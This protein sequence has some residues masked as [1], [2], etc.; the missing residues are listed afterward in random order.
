MAQS[1]YE[2]LGVQKSATQA[3][4][5]SAYRRLALKWH[6]DK[7]KE[8]GAEKKFKEINYAYEVLS[9][10]EKRGMYDQIGHEAYVRSGG[11]GGFGGAGAGGAGGWPGG[12]G[13]AGQQGPFSW[14]YQS[15]DGGAGFGGVDPFEIFEQFF[16]GAANGFRQAAR[17]PSYQITIDFFEAVDGVEKSFSIDGKKKDV[18]IPAGVD[19]GTQ[20]SF[21]EFN[22]LIH[23]QPDKTFQR[24][25][26]NV[27][28]R[29]DIPFT[30]AVLGTNI[31]VPTLDRKTVKVKVKAGTQHGSMLRLRG[32]GVKY[33][34]RSEHGDLYIVF[35]VTYPSKLS[36]KQKQLLE[37]FDN[38]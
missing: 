29:M 22:L 15:S 24:D 36:R 27:V 3:D 35:N 13:G 1:F 26:Q 20:I 38:Y 11:K 37:E 34:N 2:V 5:K 28:V 10:P 17:K 32:K 31:E 18:K 9:N 7:N 4:I 33:P 30:K 25:G 21:N 6:P 14:S 12:A 16:G 8:V 19:N 23:V